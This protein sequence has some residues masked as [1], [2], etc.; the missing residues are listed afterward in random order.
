MYDQTAEEEMYKCIHGERSWIVEVI[1]V[2]VYFICINCP[3]TIIL[4]P[5]PYIYIGI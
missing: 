5:S 2:L 3:A 1:D 4:F